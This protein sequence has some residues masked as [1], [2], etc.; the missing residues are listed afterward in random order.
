[1]CFTNKLP[2]KQIFK[3][4]QKSKIYVHTSKSEGLPVAVLEAMFVGLPVILVESPYVYGLKHHYGLLFHI[5]SG[6]LTEDLA[7][8]IL[9]VFQN[10]E[11]ELQKAALNKQIVAKLNSR[12]FRDIKKTLD[13]VMEDNY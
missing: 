6:N 8:K 7:N 12:T 5:A 4:L 11:V 1:V 9:E 13:D 2:H 3:E 10:Y